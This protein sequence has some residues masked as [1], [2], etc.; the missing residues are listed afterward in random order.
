M[1]QTYGIQG[2]CAPRFAAVREAFE[3][4]F[5]QG[6][7][8]GASFSA[9]LD[10][11]RVVDLWG[12][13]ADAEGA[14]AWEADTIVNVYST[15]KAMAALCTLML[16]DRG[17][18]DLDAPVA[19]V[20]PEFA[21]AGKESVR[22]RHL[23][24]HT[25]GL[26]GWEEAI[27]VDDLYDW[28]GVCGR[29]AAQAPWWEPGAKSGYHALTHGFL[30][31]EMVRRV[32]G[33]SLGAFFRKEVA[34]PLGADFHI[35]LAEEHE[36]RV[37]EMLPPP[38]S[39]LAAGAAVT[40]GSVAER[41]LGN[42]PLTGDVANRRAW[43][44][45]EIPAAN[46]QGN[47]RSVARIAGALACGGTLDGV[48]LLGPATLEKTIEEQCYDTDLVL[49]LPVRWGLGFGL[50]AK[51]LPIGPNPRTFFWG[52]WGGSLIVVDLDAR[53]GFAYVM[54]KMGATTMGDLRAFGPALATF[55]AL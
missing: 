49:G 11:E 41:V 8:A 54:N 29:L 42:P 20:W 5:D 27:G 53:L 52:G 6:L 18:L 45:A 19:K 22:V 10:G 12:G 51:E 47:A 15:T 1:S 30:L 44:A 40:P 24:S 38:D 48:R 43:R 26:P 14:R 16:V 34:E 7:E 25:S 21:A 36:P 3:R 37:G 55:G 31:G 13:H 46:G 28:D 17:A 35:G 33:R 50:T 9:V 23:L 32:E 4:N 2:H 39:A